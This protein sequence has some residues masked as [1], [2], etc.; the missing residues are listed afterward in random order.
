MNSW[1]DY[2]SPLRYSSKSG[3]KKMVFHLITGDIVTGRLYGIF[4]IFTF[5]CLGHVCTRLYISGTDMDLWGG[6][7]MARFPALFSSE[8]N[9]YR[10]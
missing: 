4:L 1:L 3:Q 8:I 7:D 2:I 10:S 9:E 5:S 6:C